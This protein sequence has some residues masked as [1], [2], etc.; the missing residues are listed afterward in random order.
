[1]F[2]HDHRGKGLHS[3]TLKAEDSCLLVCSAM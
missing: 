2:M 1:M 3:N